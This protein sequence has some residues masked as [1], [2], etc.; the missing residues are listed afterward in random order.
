MN[1][2]RSLFCVCSLFVFF[3]IFLSSFAIAGPTGKLIIFHAGSLAVPFAKMEK[4]FESKNPGVDIQREAGGSTKLARMI[5]E[6]GKSADIM[7]SADYAVIDKTLIPKEASW[8]V[9]FASNQLVLCYTEKSKFADVVNENN[10]YEILE[11][12]GVLWGHTDENLDPCGYRALMALQL[13]EAYY[14]K[15]GLYKKLMDNCPAENVSPKSVELISL[16]QTGKMDFA[17]EYLSVA[18]QNKLKYI[19]LPN[20]INL[21]DYRLDDYYKQAKVEVTGDKPGTKITRIGSSITYGL[22]I[23]KSAPNPDLAISFLEYMMSPEG[24]LK[25]LEESGQ[26]P[27][28]PCWVPTDEMKQKL[29]SALSSLVIVKDR[30]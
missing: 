24:G 19:K 22:T 21:G 20:E 3:V 12:K 6:E 9:R 29:P 11:R 30:K 28:I 23:V 8:N 14:K 16:L 18:V 17:W 1:R 10:W 25:I 26:P 7:A 13:A 4:E 15:P 27:F 2:S 5:S